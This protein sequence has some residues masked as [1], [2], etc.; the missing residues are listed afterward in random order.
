MPGDRVR[1]EALPRCAGRGD[2]AVRPADG[3]A[4][5]AGVAHHGQVAL[6]VGAV[7]PDALLRQPGQHPGRRVPVGVV[8]AHPDQRDPRPGGGE[9]AAVGVGAAVVRH[10]EHIGPQVD[11]A[12]D[13]PCLHRAAQVAGEQDPDPAL[14]HPDDQRQVV[15]RHRGRR[16]LRRRREHLDGRRPDRPPVAGDQD[17]TLGPGPPHR[18]LQGAGAVLGGRERAR[19]DDT[20]VPPGQRPGQPAG[21]VGVEVGD[22][23]QGQCV[24]AQ[25]VQTAVDRTDVG[26]GVHEHRLPRRGRQHQRVALADVAGDEDRPLGR[27][28]AGDLPQRPAEHQDA[29]KGGDGQR[30]GAGEAPQQ[31]AERQEQHRQQHR[32][33]GA[34]RPTGRPVGQRRRALGHDHQPPHGPP[35][36]PDQRVAQRR[37]HRERERSQQAE[38]GGGGD[39]RR[40]EQVGRQR[41]RT[42]LTGEPRH[43]RRGGQTGGRGDRDR[44]GRD[45]RPAAAAQAARPARRQQHDGRGGRD[46]EGKAGVPSEAG[47]DQQQHHDGRAEGGQRRPGPPGGQRQQRHRTHGRRPHHAGAGPGQHDEPGQGDH[48]DQ[49][50]HPPVDRP[51]PQRRQ[52]PGQHDRHVGTRD[53]REVRQPGPPEVLDEHRVHRLRVP[54]DQAGQQPTRLRP[55]H[56]AGQLAQL[57]P[58]SSGGP[59]QRRRL[60]HGHRRRPRRQPRHHALLRGGRGD[61]RPDPHHLTRQQPAPLVGR[62]E[63]DHRVVQQ[64]AR[65]AVVQRGDRGL[66]DGPR[67]THPAHRRGVPVELH[68]QLDRP[69]LVGDPGQRG[70]LPRRLPHRRRGRGDG[71]RS[72]D[73]EQH[74]RRRRPAAAGHRDRGQEGHRH[75]AG[76][77]RDGQERAEEGDG[78]DRSRRGREPQ[79]QPRPALPDCTHTVT[80]SASSA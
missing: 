60:P 56:P 36:Q 58:Q 11:A 41:H 20:D 53:G 71:E 12:R 67:R 3:H 51:A 32:A 27:P 14:G 9:E 24:D 13:D 76:Q 8:R 55:E 50:L 30:P 69:P 25:P 48:R 57:L 65:A 22:Q 29:E 18:R 70:R 43:Q 31:P 80:S 7:H 23:H 54:D 17:G 52:H 6:P 5:R 33:A 49:R 44:V 34:G 68:D 2:A 74:D 62:A 42:H 75:R 45:R 72:Q 77:D 46:G 66:D 10:L 73:A 21:V 40:G 1:R 63:E 37:H 47:V 61:R 38:H 79:V 26:P 64:G 28:P 39:G 59:L 19:G 35:G 78:P 15:G 4:P 16:D